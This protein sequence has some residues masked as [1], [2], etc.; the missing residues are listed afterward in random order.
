MLMIKRILGRDSR[1]AILS[2]RSSP[3]VR[4]LKT[5]VKLTGLPEVPMKEFNCHVEQKFEE[6]RTPSFAAKFSSGR[7]KG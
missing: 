5:K 4:T 2:K 7:K 1:L 6:T 3:L